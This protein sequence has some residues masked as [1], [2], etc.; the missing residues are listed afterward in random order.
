MTQHCVFNKRKETK[1]QF[2][3]PLNLTSNN[4]WSSKVKKRS[5]CKVSTNNF[6]SSILTALCFHRFEYWVFEYYLKVKFCENFSKQ[7]FD[8]MLWILSRYVVSSSWYNTLN[9]YLCF[10]IFSVEFHKCIDMH[11][12]ACCTFSIINKILLWFEFFD[13]KPPFVLKVLARIV[14]VSWNIKIIALKQKLVLQQ[15][16][17]QLCCCCHIVSFTFLF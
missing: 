6:F 7:V 12:F 3:L 9:S 15:W 11:T 13:I 10:E 14:N 4:L 8:S 16:S 2:W 17:S 1:N 5:Q